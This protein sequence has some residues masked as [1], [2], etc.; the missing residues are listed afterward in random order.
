MITEQAWEERPKCLENRRQG[1]ALTLASQTALALSLTVLL[2]RGYLC[3]TPLP[4]TQ[5]TKRNEVINS[6]DGTETAPHPYTRG[7]QG[8]LDLHIKSV[9]PGERKQ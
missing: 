3:H 7:A 5:K 6:L 9:Y 2:V 8:Y 1:I 4:Q